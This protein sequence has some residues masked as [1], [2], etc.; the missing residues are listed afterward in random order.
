VLD[1]LRAERPALAA[2]VVFVTG[3]IRSAEEA[4]YFERSG[5]ALLDKPVDLA[6]LRA[7]IARVAGVADVA[8][9]A[10]A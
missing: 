9:V 1:G 5:A 7:A 10:D 8:D 3:G 2:R 6:A 4:E